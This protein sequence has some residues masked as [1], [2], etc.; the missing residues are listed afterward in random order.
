MSPD[1]TVIAT[2]WLADFSRSIQDEDIAALASYFLPDGWLRDHLIFTWDTRSLLGPEAIS[3]FLSNKLSSAQLSNIKVHDAPFLHPTYGHVTPNSLGVTFAFT[4]ETPIALGKG[5]VR[6]LP[7][8]DQWKALSVFTSMA[9]LKGHEEEGAELGSWGGHTLS[10]ESVLQ[11]RR[12][13]IES[14]PQALIGMSALRRY[15]YSTL[16]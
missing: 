9:E 8:G 16:R 2:S 5:F 12:A 4:F 7:R 6:L 3:A 13:Q 14:E 11:E 1:P 15:A 10:F